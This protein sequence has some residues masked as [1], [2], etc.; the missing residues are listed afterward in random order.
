MGGEKGGLG[1]L[2]TNLSYCILLCSV[3]EGYGSI[4]F[5]YK[6]RL[7]RGVMGLR[8]KWVGIVFFWMRVMLIHPT[9]MVLEKA[10]NIGK[11]QPGEEGRLH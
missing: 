1:K 11:K 10:H 7:D 9:M 3:I 2:K 5:P 6:R 4:F 8:Y